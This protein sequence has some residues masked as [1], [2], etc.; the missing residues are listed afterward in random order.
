MK[1]K[2]LR[3]CFIGPSGLGK[4]TC[5][6]LLK[7]HFQNKVKIIK[8]AEPLYK[9][10]QKIY[11]NFELKIN[12]N[13]Q[14]GELLQLLGKRVQK[15]NPTFLAKKFLNKLKSNNNKQ[16][17]I[18]DDCRPHNFKYLKENNFIFIAIN[19]HSRIRT[20]DLS[21]I[22][23]KDSV[24]W[25]KTNSLFNADFIIKNDGTKADLNKKIIELI[26]K[27]KENKYEVY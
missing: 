15:L 5:S 27:I 7:K 4:S 26:T 9:I 14:D 1:E 6:Y 8:L 24:E 12:E 11:N 3:I 23:K 22:N 25:T 2:Q 18:N 20:N 13:I 21:K 17:I 16:I 10:Q 19:G